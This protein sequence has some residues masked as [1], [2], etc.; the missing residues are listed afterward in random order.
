M[1]AYLLGCEGFINEPTTN[2]EGVRTEGSSMSPTK[3]TLSNL[4]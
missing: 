2:R 1:L 4:A 3:K